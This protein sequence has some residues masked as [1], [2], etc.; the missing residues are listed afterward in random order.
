MRTIEQWKGTI[1]VKEEKKGKFH[2]RQSRVRVELRAVGGK[3][4]RKERR[5]I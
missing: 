2:P 5:Q 3:N 4:K 1:V